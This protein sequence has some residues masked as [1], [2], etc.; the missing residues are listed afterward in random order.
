MTRV[1]LAV[2][3]VALAV[4]LAV[5]AA[6]GLRGSG[7]PTQTTTTTTERAAV[8]S[9]YDFTEAAPDVD[10]SV[11]PEAKFASL[12]LQ[13]AT[14]VKSYLIAVDNPAFP[15]LARAV[16]GASKSTEEV[17]GGA[18]GA[19]ASDAGATGDEATRG[20]AS[21]ATLTFVMPDRTTVTFALD[22]EHGLLRRKGVTLKP[23]GDLAALVDAAVR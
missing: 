4:L 14:G 21:G 1:R 7:G 11:V 13:T 23:A 19:G 5:G 16:A 8:T 17:G 10:L 12:T 18:K 3:G 6:V 2:G 20:E 9:P 22:L 15:P